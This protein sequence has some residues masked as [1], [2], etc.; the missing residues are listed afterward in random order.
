MHVRRGTGGNMRQALA[1][2]V[3]A[4][5][6]ATAFAQ[7]RGTTELA[8]HAV[9]ESGR[10]LALSR[11]ALYLDADT[12][13][14]TVAL[15]RFE[16]GTRLI[17]DRSW[18]C[19]Q[20]QAACGRPFLTG[21]L[22]LQA[23]GRAPIV[24]RPFDWLGGERFVNGRVEPV[25]TVRIEFPGNVLVEIKEGDAR[26]LR[27]PFRLV[28]P[29]ALHVVDEEG[30]PIAE[31]EI[32][33]EMFFG[34]A[35]HCGGTIGET[36][37]AGVTNA[38]GE[39]AVSDMEAE[40]AFEFVKPHYVLTKPDPTG[41]PM[42]LI[43][44][45]TSPMTRVTLHRQVRQ[46]LR[47]VFSTGGRALAGRTLDGCLANCICGPCCGILATTDAAGRVS[48]EDFYP[49][50]IG[51][52]MLKDERGGVVWESPSQAVAGSGWVSVEVP[53]KRDPAEGVAPSPGVHPT[54]AP[55]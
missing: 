31:V 50:E 14:R 40:Y 28:Q 29:R 17:L 12:D 39:V 45:L 42:R 22:I 48:V 27:L 51:R 24:T 11:A 43:T 26:E 13:R 35:G 55:R 44:S 23:D 54:A 37:Q 33:A 18:V 19:A 30:T 20:W 38:R 41:Y 32:R 2:G 46:P 7:S 5:S 8:I 47:L 49:E 10:T 3:I 16:H 6:L 53:R 34:L 36:I 52:L 1:A 21:R 4:A 9:D 15:G 25:R